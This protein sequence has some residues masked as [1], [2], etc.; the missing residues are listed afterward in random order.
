LYERGDTESEQ[1][2]AMKIEGKLLYGEEKKERD[3]GGKGKLGSYKEDKKE[4]LS[5]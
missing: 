3:R 2:R 4:I 5:L 1:E